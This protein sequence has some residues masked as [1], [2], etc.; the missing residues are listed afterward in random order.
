MVEKFRF[1]FTVSR[2]GQFVASLRLV[3]FKY[4]VPA[5]TV[6]LFKPVHPERHDVPNV[7]SEPGK[8][9]DS[10]DEQYSNTLELIVTRVPGRLILVRLVHL[11]KQLIDRVVVPSCNIGSES[12]LF[13]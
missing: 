13:R 10:R 11:E 1:M 5:S 12:C 9:R 3:P 4:P 8:L 2:L 6:R 7:V